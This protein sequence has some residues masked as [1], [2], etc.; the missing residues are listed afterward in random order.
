[1]KQLG[2]KT[3]HSFTWKAGFKSNGVELDLITDDKLTSLLEKQQ[4]SWHCICDG[5]S[6]HKGNDTR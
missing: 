4:E 3:T 2:Y 1:M 6:I 5:K